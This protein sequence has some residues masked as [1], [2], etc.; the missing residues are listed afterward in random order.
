MTKRQAWLAIAKAFARYHRTGRESRL[1]RTGLC[2][3]VETLYWDE[4]ISDRTRHAMAC[5]IRDRN[6]FGGYIWEVNRACAASRA[7]L[8]GRLAR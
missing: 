4:R 3:A 8:A 6:L 5:Q 7:Q 2:K 1:T